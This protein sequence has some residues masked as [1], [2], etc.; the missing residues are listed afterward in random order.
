[1]KRITE[2]LNEY[3]ASRGL[4]GEDLQRAVSVDLDLAL[5]NSNVDIDE[6]DE[7]SMI[8]YW[9]QSPEGHDYWEDRNSS[10]KARGEP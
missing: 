4:S 2:Q 6:E 8:F 5:A 7:I 1:M 10:A 9:D 3:H